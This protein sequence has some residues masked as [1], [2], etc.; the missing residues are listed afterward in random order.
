MRFQVVGIFWK[1]ELAGADLDRDF[2]QADGAEPADV[3]RILDRLEGLFGKFRL[4][5]GNTPYKNVGVQQNRHR[6]TADKLVELTLRHGLIPALLESDLSLSAAKNRPPR[7]VDRNELYH[8]HT[9]LRDDYLIARPGF[10]D[11]L[12]EVSLS[13][14]NID[15]HESSIN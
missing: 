8:R 10:L 1:I 4:L 7:R 13:F 11:Q 2:P 12:R 14:V 3:I 9:C 15:F 6:L 5:T